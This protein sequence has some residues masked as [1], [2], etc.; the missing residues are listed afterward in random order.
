VKARA[1][2]VVA[3]V[4]VVA[5]PAAHANGDP[6][7]DALPFGTVFLSAQEPSSLPSGRALLT[8]TKEAVKKRFPV[9]VAVIWQPSDLGLI[10]SLWLKPQPYATFLGKELASFGRYHGTLVVTMPNGFGVFGPGATAAAKRALAALP[11]PG[12][13]DANSLGDATVQAV[14][15]VASANGHPLP[16]PPK[17][18]GGTPT[19]VILL[20][21]LGGAAVVGAALFLGLRRWLT[22]A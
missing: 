10:G 3:L 17:Q 22:H 7:S 8:L 15:A 2:V 16:A 14:L 21:A 18:S 12:N 11:K 9:R 6:A 1:L 13:G 20:A 5:A 19:W 4:A